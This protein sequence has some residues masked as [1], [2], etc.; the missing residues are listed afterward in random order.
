MHS[1]GLTCALSV[2]LESQVQVLL[3]AFADSVE[4]Y[5]VLVQQHIKQD[6]INDRQNSIGTKSIKCVNISMTLNSNGQFA[7][8]D[9]WQ[10]FPNYSAT[11]F[12]D[13]LEC[14]H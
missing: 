7:S 12:R 8:C 4:N 10:N 5:G 11:N 3:Q 1:D 9:L 13:S 6:D 14:H 2:I